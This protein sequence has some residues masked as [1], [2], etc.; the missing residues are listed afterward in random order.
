MRR[1]AP[2][3]L[4]ALLL[5]GCGAPALIKPPQFDQ[6]EQWIQAG[7]KVDFAVTQT[8]VMIQR[9]HGAA[10]L[11]DLYMRLGEL[12][13]ERARY[14]WLVAYE[15]HKARG[16]DSRAVESPEA[17]LLKSLAIGTYGRVL[18]EFPSYARGDEAL[19]L[20]G[21][22]YR[23]LGDFDKM[24]EAYERL[25]ST[26]ATSPHRLEAY[27]AL[28]DHAFDASDLPTAEKYYRSI[29][30]API[31]PVHA[32]ARYK[33][34]W[35]RVNQQD[36]KGAVTLF[37]TTLREGIAGRASAALLST[38]KD[39]NVMREALVDLAYCYPEVYPDKPA[40]PY[41]RDLATSAVDY[42]AA[43]RKLSSRFAIKEM[44]AQAARALR[45]V[46]D[47]APGEEDGPELVRRLHAAVIKGSVFDSPA[48]DVER[49]VSVLDTRLADYRLDPAARN[50]ITDEFE[51]YARD[52]ATRAHVAAKA[53][54]AQTALSQVADAYRAYLSRFG[55][56]PAAG[57][58]RENWA[59]S[60]LAA[61]RSF[62]A[63]KAYEE[64]EGATKK[65][66]TKKLARLN[67]IASYQQAIDDP[68]LGRL[69][70]V[71]AWGGIRSLGRRFIQETPSDA[72]VP[73][74][75]LSIARSYYETGD[76][77]TAAELFFGLARQF[78]TSNEGVAGAN[79]CLDAMRLADNLEG[80][81]TLGRL[82]VADTRLRADVR[83][84][85]GD[86][87]SKAAQR[88]VAEVTASDSGDREE[89]LLAMAKRNK[90]SEIG[91][92][93]FYNTLL[94][95]RSNGEI[96]KFYQL[97]D[98]FL[99]DYP[100]S[101]RRADVLT[102][103]AAVGSDI[104]DFPK[105]AK[106]DAAA[107]AADP[108]AKDAIERLVAAASM[109]A[110]LGDP[111]ATDEIAKLAERGNSK[112]DD[113]LLLLA[114]SGNFAAL[115]GVL[116]RTSVT[117]PVATFFNGYAAFRHADFAAA[118]ATLS[119]LSGASPDLTARARFLLAEITYGDFKGISG[120][121]DL[122]G[123]I[124]ANAKGLAAVDRAYKPVI[125]AGEAP[126]AMFGVARLADANA[127][128]AAVLRGLEP[129]AGLP[130]QDQKTLK[131]AL[132]AQAAEAEK[133]S[134]ELKAV[135]V[136]QAKKSEI[137]SEATKSCL[138]DQPLPE[139][140]P[141]YPQVRRGTEPAG[142]PAIRQAL[143]KNAKDTTALT[144]LAE[145]Y[146]GA[147][148]IASALLILE[149]AEPL[150][151]RKA[152]IKNLLGLT[153]QQLGEPQEA[154]DAFKETVVLEPNDPQWHLNLAA[155]YA[156]FG[157]NDRAKAELKKAGPVP[158]AP[159]SPIDHPDI[160][161]LGQLSDTK[162]AAP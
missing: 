137:F 32:L 133:R 124:D 42:L 60:L 15:K 35:V 97:G 127:K 63:G 74:I 27:L 76:Y 85:L 56:T 135:C 144:K 138:L 125:E 116:T 111:A 153:M 48:H 24:K 2:I 1:L 33:L 107:F 55:T 71:V 94:L 16:D 67:A 49:V 142:A 22:E 147:G 143:L 21:F 92:E 31:S 77:E 39:L 120:Q 136:K 128:F 65:P 62:D 54:Q 88:E 38:Q 158:A 160:R 102:A 64:L 29:L 6:S 59:E 91:E 41:F 146:L 25:I 10:Y 78:P 84:D 4:A 109:H 93:A 123:T 89:Q 90:G 34:A 86:I 7:R 11:P 140:I 72:A 162:K 99:T 105:A 159:R 70:R 23:E 151:G 155:Q 28:G 51:L 114:R 113:L 118:R 46:L 13:T 134:S 52:I 126:W 139:T 75:K 18:R 17:R 50:R 157:Y 53:S 30:A 98:Q 81:T 69:D 44:P 14:S 148:D 110:V 161:L 83:K 119:K 73:G 68:A 47:G 108:Q 141:M 121:G 87:V 104:G 3:A 58:I 79:L 122:A 154:G 96:E 40:T 152:P 80:L 129:P 149:R 82:L 5:S 95:A 66:D 8:K 156:A 57:D 131:A 101:P 145:L 130:A 37:E 9:A 150:G 115:E 20:T 36:C 117:G 19:F 106:Y 61:K 26:Y 100:A 43:M 103:L 112:V 12:Y 45:E 132:D